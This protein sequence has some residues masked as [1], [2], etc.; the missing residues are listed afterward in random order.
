MEPNGTVFVKTSDRVEKNGIEKAPKTLLYA[1]FVVHSTGVKGA[2]FVVYQRFWVKKEERLHCIKI[3]VLAWQRLNKTIQCNPLARNIRK[4][5]FFAC[6]ISIFSRN[7][8]DDPYEHQQKIS[9]N[10]IDLKKQ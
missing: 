10:I 5:S 3:T 6:N 8:F 2:V 9:K 4:S 7:N 1:D